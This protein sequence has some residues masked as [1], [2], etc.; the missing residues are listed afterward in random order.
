MT[1]AYLLAYTLGV[2]QLT[3]RPFSQERN[4]ALFRKVVFTL[5]NKPPP[6]TVAFEPN[7]W[8]K[9]SANMPWFT[10]WNVTHGGNANGTTPSTD[11]ILPPTCPTKNLCAS[12]SKIFTKLMVL[13]SPCELRENIVLTVSWLPFSSQCHNWSKVCWNAPWGFEWSYSWGSCPSK[14]LFWQLLAVTV[15]GGWWAVTGSSRPPLLHC[16]WPSWT[17]QAKSLQALPSTGL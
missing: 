10:E 1:W 16:S 14:C 17:I 7:S 6:H 2:K 11:C 9:P 3:V 8:S 12:P 13:Y 15:G 5:R 4:K